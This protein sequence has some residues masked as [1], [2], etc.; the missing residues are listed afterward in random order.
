[1]NR[2]IPQSNTPIA[3]QAPGHSV[4]GL[5]CRRAP[6][7]PPKPRGGQGPPRM[8]SIQKAPL[9]RFG[10]GGACTFPVTASKLRK[11]VTLDR[12][13]LAEYNRHYQLCK[14]LAERQVEKK[15]MDFVYMLMGFCVSLSI[16]LV[17]YGTFPLAFTRIR[18]KPIAKKTCYA[19]CYAVNFVIWIGLIVF[20]LSKSPVPYIL[21]TGIFTKLPPSRSMMQR[22]PR[23]RRKCRQTRRT[24]RHRKRLSFLPLRHPFCFADGAAASSVPTARFAVGAA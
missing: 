2:R 1:M 6:S 4:R 15:T 8:R 11:D 9:N 24:N 19:I 7:P 13:L 5:C 20:D 23:S 16:T 10:F 14:M 17:A 12:K 22:L 21:W 3:Q 18:K